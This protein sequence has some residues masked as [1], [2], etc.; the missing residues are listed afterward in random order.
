MAAR[1]QL[2]RGGPIP[3]K[4]PDPVAHTQE[5][6]V[7]SSVPDSSTRRRL[8]LDLRKRPAILSIG[9]L[10]VV[11][12]LLALV[13]W[14]T[15]GTEGHQL[16][17]AETVFA[18]ALSSPTPSSPTP[19][20]VYQAILP[21]LVVIRTDSGAERDGFGIGSGIV[22]NSEAEILTALHIVENAAEIQIGFA[23]GTKTV[24]AIVD[25]DPERDIAVLTP[26]ALPNFVLP[27]TIGSASSMRVGDEVFAVGN[28]LGLAGSMSA[29]V[30]S[31]LERDFKP[32]GRE[33]PLQGLIQFDAA[34]N[35]GNSGGPLLNRYGQVVGI[36]TGLINPSDQNVFIGIGFAVPIDVAVSAAGGPA[37]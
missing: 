3:P 35:P 19:A 20:Q 29:G 8:W 25:M 36:V 5:S 33:Q 27:A 15:L 21:S 26:A 23:D 6:P 18:E 17:S 31:G 11:A 24:A 34:V 16:S 12:L 7:G 30:L 4:S 22:V 28:P 10:V 13:L 14:R 1:R 2:S 32:S 37:Q 9:A